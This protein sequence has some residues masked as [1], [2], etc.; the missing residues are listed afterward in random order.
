MLAGELIGDFG[1]ELP[2]EE[3]LALKV[4]ARVMALKNVNDRERQIRVVNGDIGEVIRFNHRGEPVVQFPDGRVW[5]VA[6]ESWNKLKLRLEREG[7][8]R[9]I[10]EEVT[11]TFKQ[12]PLK[13]AW[14]I[15]VHKSQGQTLQTAVIDFDQQSRTHGKTYVALSRVRS[16]D[17]LYLRRPL[18]PSDLHINQRVREFV[19]GDNAAP[20]EARFAGLFA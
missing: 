6:Q 16:G 1:R 2:A 20:T 8:K 11:G 15:T 12:F 9:T 17:G 3:N 4:G 19:C 7:K 5:D 13:L 18:R 14:G 10:H